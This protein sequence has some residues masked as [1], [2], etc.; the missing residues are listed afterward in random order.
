MLIALIAALVIYLGGNNGPLVLEQLSEGIPTAVTDKDKAE[1]L[2]EQVDQMAALA[3][4]YQKD[5]LEELEAWSE[6]DSRHSV[7]PEALNVVLKTSL[8]KRILTE[9]AFLDRL[10]ALKSEMT[11]DQWESVFKTSQ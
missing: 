8:K 7:G 10:Y 11:K 3:E 6:Q 9:R 5:M 4:D 2:L 1:D